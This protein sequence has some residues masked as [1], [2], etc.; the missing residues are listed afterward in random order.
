MKWNAFMRCAAARKTAV[1]APAG[2]TS[3][4]AQR[5]KTPLDLFLP[6]AFFM[7]IGAQLF[8]AFMLIYFAFA[9]FL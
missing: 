3:Q 1:R 6:G 9:T 7:A 8:A 5:P 2:Y 4:P